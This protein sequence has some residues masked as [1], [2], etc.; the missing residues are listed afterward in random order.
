MSNTKRPPDKNIPVPVFLYWAVQVTMPLPELLQQPAVCFHYELANSQNQGCD[1]SIQQAFDL[2]SVK[3][4]WA[5]LWKLRS[6]AHVLMKPWANNTSTV[7]STGSL[8]YKKR[9]LWWVVLG[10]TGT[11]YCLLCS[12]GGVVNELKLQPGGREG[13]RN[14]PLFLLSSASHLYCTYDICDTGR[15]PGSLY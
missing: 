14:I 8:P 1:T 15:L 2:S 13:S 6:R 11:W 7:S 4:P 9:N 12:Q 5:V 10:S 3:F